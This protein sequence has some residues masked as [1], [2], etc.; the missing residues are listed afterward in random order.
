MLPAV[1]VLA[2]AVTVFGL[3]WL[4]L[5]SKLV[6][7]EAAPAGTSLSLGGLAV[8]FGAG[9]WVMKVGRQPE[10]VPM[11]TGLALGVAITI[12]AAIAPF[13]LF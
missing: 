12:G 5:D 11:L 4:M 9:A 7:P 1:R 6:T 3:L 13:F 2:T 8:V 10:R